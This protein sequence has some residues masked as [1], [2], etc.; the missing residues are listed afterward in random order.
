MTEAQN[1]K[2]RCNHCHSKLEFH[3]S[4]EGQEISCPNCRYT[5]RL[6]RP[7][8]APVP[9]AAALPIVIPPFA[10][11]ALVSAAASASPAAASVG[12]IRAVP[13][14]PPSRPAQPSATPTSVPEMAA[15]Q[16][17]RMPLP[18]PVRSASPLPVPLA[19]SAPLAASAPTMPSVPVSSNPMVAMPVRVGPV[20]P[21]E[22]P[23]EFISRVR[24]QTCYPQLRNT[25]KFIHQFFNA[26]VITIFALFAASFIVSTI[27]IWTK[28]SGTTQERWLNTLG[29]MIFMLL[30]TLFCFVSRYVERA[31]YQ[32]SNLGID[33]ADTLVEQ[34]RRK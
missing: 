29:A 13:A 6:F 20:G 30:L 17:I 8:D 11:S 10:P 15:T 16:P 3:A 34:N 2:C 28:D 23:E 12:G 33:V 18:P 32:A 14:A 25:L 4:M 5:T 1:V 19:T 21:A 9:P 27:F 26:F 31:I 24:E 7:P 22:P